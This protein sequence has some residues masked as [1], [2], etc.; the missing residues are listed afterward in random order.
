MRP[1]ACPQLIRGSVSPMNEE[2]SDRPEPIAGV[3]TVPERADGQT[4]LGGRAAKV[5]EHPED[6]H[7]DWQSSV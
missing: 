4:K 1:P 7:E 2:R 5:G 6:P 3:I